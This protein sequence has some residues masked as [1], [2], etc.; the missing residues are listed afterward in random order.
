VT[1]ALIVLVPTTNGIEVLADP[2]ETLTRFTFSVAVESVTVGV[3]II[4][5]VPLETLAV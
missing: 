5:V 2:E 1:T 4:E 3:I